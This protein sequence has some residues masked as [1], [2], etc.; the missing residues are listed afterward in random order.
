M[1]VHIEIIELQIYDVF[2][3]PHSEHIVKGGKKANPLIFEACAGID[4]KYFCYCWRTSNNILYV[5]S[6][7]ADYT[8]SQHKNN[9]L[10]RLGNYLQN[11]S[12]T[13]NK[14]VFDN[15]N[16]TLSKATVSL[17]LF[18]FKCIAL[19]NDRWNYTDC[20]K[21]PEVMQMLEEILIC[22]YRLLGQAQWN[23]T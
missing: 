4:D 21:K 15:I 10:G 16:A 2:T 19:D 17:G 23:R 22:R 12:G 13:T 6:V 3:I 1:N 14:M 9:L 20:S 7:T 11:H 5:G 8:S 18:R